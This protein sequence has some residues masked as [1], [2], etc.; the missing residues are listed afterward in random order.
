MQQASS[1]F[2]AQTIVACCRDVRALLALLLSSWMSVACAN[3]A[4]K[5][6]PKFA[7]RVPESFEFAGTESATTRCSRQ[8]VGSASPAPLARA[9]ARLVRQRAAMVSGGRR[10]RTGRHRSRRP[11]AREREAWQLRADS[12][13]F[14]RALIDTVAAQHPIDRTRILSV[15]SSGGVSSMRSRCRCW[16]SQLFARDGDSRGRVAH[17]ER[18]PR[19]AYA[20]RKIPIAMFIGDKDEYFPLFAGAQDAERARAGRPSGERPR[21]SPGTITLMRTS[22][23]E[24]NRSAWE[25]MKAHRL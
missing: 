7:R 4:L 12:P 16:K 24:V 14:I 13:Q 22:R 21:S 1:S 20:K 8:A 15:R 2:C 18:V 11:E 25:F 9:A 23:S 10:W 19:G 3:A 5:T 6:R 17:A